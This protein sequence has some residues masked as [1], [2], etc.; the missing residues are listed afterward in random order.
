MAGM[1]LAAAD[2]RNTAAV[3][4]QTRID[5]DGAA[6]FLIRDSFSVKVSPDFTLLAEGMYHIRENIDFS[7][8]GLGAA[9]VLGSGIYSQLLYELRHYGSAEFMHRIYGDT[10]YETA[11]WLGNLNVSLFLPS[12]SYSLAVSPF[13]RY[14]G[15]E[16]VQLQAKYILGI[17][18]EAEELL[19]HTGQAQVSVSLNPFEFTAGGGG[20]TFGDSGV[21][22]SGWNIFGEIG[23]N[24]SDTSKL[25]YSVTYSSSND[26][27]RMLANRLVYS[28]QW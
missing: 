5:R 23:W 10:T 8:G 16:R 20:G 17:I 28:T 3:E 1:L 4:A 24:V 27:I 2:F 22:K 6:S 18:P 11:S 12:G 21:I 15:W 26:G 13:F 14:Y 7:G 9:A 25:G 19:A